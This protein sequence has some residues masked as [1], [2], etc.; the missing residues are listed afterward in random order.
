MVKISGQSLDNVVMSIPDSANITSR[1]PCAQRA[2]HW[3]IAA[4]Q[5]ESHVGEFASQRHAAQPS[6]R[7][8]AANGAHDHGEPFLAADDRQPVRVL[9]YHRYHCADW[10]DLGSLLRDFVAQLAV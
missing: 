2:P 4:D 7:P 9:H 5:G 8:S 6:P 10:S 1:W 3:P